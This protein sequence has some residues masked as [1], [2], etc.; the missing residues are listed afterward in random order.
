VSRPDDKRLDDILEA[1][2]EIGDI[3]ARGRAAFDEDVALR[4]AMERCLELV[5][6]AA[7]SLSADVRDS[8]PSV[9]WSQV[10]RLRDRL[11]HHYHRVE[12]NLVVGAA[13]VDVPRLAAAIT[14]WRADPDSA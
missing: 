10:I 4:R 1:T 8:I 3:V 13:E 11:S 14:A 5:G 6:E 12:A 9:P 2:S 7:K